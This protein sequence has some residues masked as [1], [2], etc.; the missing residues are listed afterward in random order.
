MTSDLSNWTW[1]DLNQAKNRLSCLLSIIS[2]ERN[3]RDHKHNMPLHLI[4]RQSSLFPWY[5]SVNPVLNNAVLDGVLDCT[6][7]KHPI[8]SGR[9]ALQGD[10]AKCSR[11]TTTARGEKNDW[12]TEELKEE[13]KTLKST[14]LMKHE[15]D[16][17]NTASSEG[18]ITQTRWWW[19]W[20]CQ[21]NLKTQEHTSLIRL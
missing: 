4:V 9:K 18:I 3:I 11:G 1:P 17:Q 16:T 21:Q 6:R 20:W 8:I 2:N 7:E 15:R 5:K 12:R 14:E 13:R 10:G 19:W